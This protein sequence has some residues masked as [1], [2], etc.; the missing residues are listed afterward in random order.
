VERALRDRAVAEER[1]R[2][3]PSPRSCAAVAAPTAIGSPR[4]RCRWRRRS[5]GRIGDVHRAA[6]P[7][8]RALVLGHQLGEHP[9]RVEALGE[10][11][12][13]ARGAST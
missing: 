12:A 5:R 11:V 3:A 8:V 1:H 10:A 9:E 13:V 6:A 2:H 4:R 7:A